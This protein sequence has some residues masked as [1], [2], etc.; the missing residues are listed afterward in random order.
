MPD[1]WKYGRA[2]DHGTLRY[3]LDPRDP[4]WEIARDIAQ[5]IAGALLLKPAEYV[6]PDQRVTATWDTLNH[7]LL[8]NCDV[9]F[10]F[11]LIP[12]GYPEWLSVSRAYYTASYALAV[13]DPAWQSLA[14]VP[15]DRPIATAIGTSADFALT[16]YIQTQPAGARWT[17]FPMGTNETAL[18]A[19]EDG[20]A[21]A[22]LVWG[23]AAWAIGQADPA[24][25]GIRLVPI[26]PLPDTSHGVG[27]A[28]LAKQSFLRASVDQAIGDLAADGTIAGILAAHEFP[29]R[30]GP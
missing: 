10:G 28:L 26:A 6:V 23:P 21:G 24:Y 1:D 22:A 15:P 29:A 16:K 4:E 18:A 11:K 8:R 2:E 3:C 14:D 9:Y 7:H 27:A 13:E 5:A 17:R 30:A 12:G 19:L 20:T 25:A